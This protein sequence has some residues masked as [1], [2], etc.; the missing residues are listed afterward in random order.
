MAFEVSN[1]PQSAVLQLMMVLMLLKRDGMVMIKEMIRITEIMI[2]I[3][4]SVLFIM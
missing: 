1:G 3:L 2:R 4:P